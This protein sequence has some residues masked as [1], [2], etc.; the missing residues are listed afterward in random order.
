M[1]YRSPRADSMR[2]ATSTAM[3]PD[4]DEPS[5]E[6]SLARKNKMERL[7]FLEQQK[8][9]T[10]NDT[11]GMVFNSTMDTGAMSIRPHSLFRRKQCD[12]DDADDLTDDA[13]T[14]PKKKDQHPSEDSYHNNNDHTSEH[15]RRSLDKDDEHD[16]HD[17]ADSP[18]SS[19]RNL[20]LHRSASLEMNNTEK[21]LMNRGISSVYDPTEESD[22]E[23]DASVVQVQA[24]PETENGMSPK[25]R[26][27]RESTS[28]T[29]GETASLFKYLLQNKREFVNSP[30]P[31]D[32]T[33]RCRIK[34]SKKDGKHP[35]YSLYIELSDKGSKEFLLQAKKRNKSKTSNYIIMDKSGDCLVDDYVGKLRS[36]FLGSEYVLFD[37]GAAPRGFQSKGTR[38]ELAS[39]NYETNPFGLKGPRKM[40]VVI[41]GMTAEKKMLDFEPK[42]P[43][44]R[45]LAEKKAC[46]DPRAEGVS[47]YWN[48]APVWRTETQSFVLNFNGRVTLPSVKNFQIVST[49]DGENL[50]C[51]PRCRSVSSVCRM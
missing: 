12:D 41:P 9:K 30:A 22:D 33:V 44:A 1:L 26:G 15:H 20:R 11:A 2:V 19:V 3:S 8:R 50:G 10:R 6:A 24:P 47:V 43:D 23:K 14:K 35:C 13:S 51:N 48:K 39:I 17:I 7:K 38:K 49:D 32:T 34:R 25:T 27:T 16:V 31:E 4:T 42:T 21:E 37:S 36:N 40:I 46:D 18:T 5:S 29:P 45:L 28:Q